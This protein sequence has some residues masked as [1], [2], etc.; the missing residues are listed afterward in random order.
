[1]G[2]VTVSVDEFLID[3][4]RSLRAG[5]ASA[6]VG[7]GLSQAGGLP[8]WN[9]LIA[10]MRAAANVPD[11]IRDPTV[12]AE[13]IEVEIGAKKLLDHVLA[14]TF[15]EA[16]PSETHRLLTQ[17]GLRRLWTTNYDQFLER[18]FAANGFAIINDDDF[19]RL[20]DAGARTVIVKLH[21][22]V[23]H[24]HNNLRAWIRPPIITR[25][26]YE[27]F[28]SERPLLWTD[29][30]ANFL[31]TSFLFLGFS[32][33]DPNIEIL[34]KLSRSVPRTIRRLNH[35]AVMK[36]PADPVALRLAELRWRDL[37]RAGIKVV[38]VESYSQINELLNELK[39]RLRPAGLFVSGSAL[40]PQIERLFERTGGLLASS[41][42]GW[43]LNSL[44]SQAARAFGRGVTDGL[45]EINRYDPERLR[46][47]F[48]GG[49]RPTGI[50]E[51]MGTVV[52]HEEEDKDL[53]RQRV[54]ADSRVVLA[55]GGSQGTERELELAASFG[56]PVI[57]LP[58]DGASEE[59]FFKHGVPRGVTSPLLW[60]IMSLADEDSEAA[61]RRLS[62][63]LRAQL[64]VSEPTS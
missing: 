7:A 34:L 54:F 4:S 18:A 31:T 59:F 11:G 6:F 30:T 13:Y 20:Q 27:T 24:D 45:K 3:F 47:H 55:A 53:V 37:D 1:M 33:D 63:L 9:E 57:A 48:R 5:L 60:E 22:S 36:R 10:P 39:R 46:F 50:P 40:S 58:T 29:V 26:H 14:A 61:A 49:T 62:E 42:P 38:A 51:R 41:D 8:G 2:S 56:L 28:A 19:G 21:G 44:S 43:H 16:T 17:L 12:A 25:S 35:Y 52:Y 23:G 32:F 64:G 15:T